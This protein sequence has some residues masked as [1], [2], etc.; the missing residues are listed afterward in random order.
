MVSQLEVEDY[1]IR[2]VQRIAVSPKNTVAFL[3]NK[4][5]TQGHTFR[6]KDNRGLLTIN[7]K[8]ELINTHGRGLRP[9]QISWLDVKYRT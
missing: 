2:K 1:F 3:N 9:A 7:V 6:M 5:L 4:Y 8:P